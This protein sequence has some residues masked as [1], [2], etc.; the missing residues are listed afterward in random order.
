MIRNQ[1]AGVWEAFDVY[2]SLA[3]RLESLDTAI[4]A[5]R[6]PLACGRWGWRFSPSNGMSHRRAGGPVGRADVQSRSPHRDDPALR[7]RS[8]GRTPDFR[9]AWNDREPEFAAMKPTAVVINVGRGPVIEEEALVSALSQAYQRRRP[10]CFRSRA[11][12]TGHPFYKLENVLL[13][14]HCADH[15]PDWLESHAVLHRSARKISR[16]EAA[17]ECSEE[18][19]RL[20]R[21]RLDLDGGKNEI[22][23]T[24]DPIRRCGH[25]PQK[26][27][28]RGWARAA[29][30]TKPSTL[31]R[32]APS[33]MMLRT[34][35]F[36]STSA[37]VFRTVFACNVQL[38]VTDPSTNGFTGWCLEQRLKERRMGMTARVLH[39]ASSTM[40]TIS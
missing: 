8:R 24:G 21:Y 2:A 17:L 33:A 13:S 15:T 23:Q 28:E 4:S 16:R 38:D 34:V 35:R 12:P 11:L 36:G 14:P 10:G 31:L 20:L 5:A 3:K 19:T 29:H 32:S 39:F 37:W 6:S 27:S 25:Q 9:D 1:M 7:L 26:T 30:S 40:P 18:G 22:R